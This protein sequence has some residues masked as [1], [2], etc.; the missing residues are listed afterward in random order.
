MTDEQTDLTSLRKA[1]EDVDR[2]ILEKLKQRMELAEGVAHAKLTTAVPFRDPTRE[3]QVILRVRQQAAELGLDAHEIERLYR[4][5]MEMAIARQQGHLRSL[6]TVPLR[7]AY[8]GA[9]GSYSHLA[10]QARYAG[11]KGGVLLLGYDTLGEA[12]EGLRRGEADFALLP[13]ENTTAGSMNETYDL[14]AEGKA[15]ITA[16]VV[17][18]VE[19]RL[20]A[21]PGAS[22]A[23][24]EVI[25]SHPQAFAQCATFLKTLPHV[26]L[27]PEQDTAG[28]ARKVAESHDPRRAAIA[29]AS[30]GDRF[31]LA[32]LPVE[33]QGTN[34]D[35]TRYVEVALEA[36]PCPAD[37]PC[38]TSLLMVLSHRPGALGGVLQRF[39]AHG[40]NLA[41]IE[42]RPMAGSPWRYRFYLDVEGHAASKELTAALEEV[43]PVALELRVLGTYPRAATEEAGR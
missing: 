25:Y 3:Q 9:E 23:G 7:V 22:L 2:L 4:L 1:I 16:E 38:R 42:S 43:K 14:L 6:D 41:K 35:F 5:I 37:V 13:I 40:V 32:Q 34:G 20:L 15:S 39:A 17:N 26:R 8:Q 29:S 27:Q 36:A 18:R 11:R 28:A 31:G 19:H 33:L 30:A 24:I 12:V 21:L 10:A